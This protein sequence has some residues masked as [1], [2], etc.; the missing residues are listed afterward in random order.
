MSNQC[1]EMDEKAYD[2]ETNNKHGKQRIKG[3][4][5][6]AKALETTCQ[7]DNKE[8]VKGVE[9][10]RVF[11][12]EEE[13][14]EEEEVVALQRSLS[15]VNLKDLA[16]EEAKLNASMTRSTSDGHINA[17]SEGSQPPSSV[18]RIIQ[19]AVEAKKRFEEQQEAIDAEVG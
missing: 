15:L 6:P 14:E 9:E 11:N 12:D 8:V 3:K 10:E 17:P 4:E 5:S 13:G 19:E 7:S 1:T 2:E 16:E 18:A